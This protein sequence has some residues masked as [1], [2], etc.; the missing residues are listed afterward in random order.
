LPELAGLAD[1][2]R[3][4]GLV[5]EEDLIRQPIRWTDSAKLRSVPSDTKCSAA[6]LAEAQGYEAVLPPFTRIIWPVIK[7]ALCE[8]TNMIASA[9]SSGFPARRCAWSRRMSAT[10]YAYGSWATE[11]VA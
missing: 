9:I 4:Q 1:I 3:V 7:F 6:S 11:L 2:L 8:E 10:E 5:D